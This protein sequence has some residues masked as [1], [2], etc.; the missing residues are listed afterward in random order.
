MDEVNEANANVKRLL[1]ARLLDYTVIPELYDVMKFGSYYAFVQPGTETDLST[2]AFLTYTSDTCDELPLFTSSK[3]PLMQEF[4]NKYD[5]QPI[6]VPACPLFKRLKD[7]V[8]EEGNIQVAL[9]P[10]TPG[11]IRIDRPL[12][13]GLL[14]IW[15][16]LD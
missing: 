11:G 8:T 7:I 10:Q 6:N 4:L 13:I 15:G 1:E 2:A 9:N 14:S 5:I 16:Q 12:L 3:L